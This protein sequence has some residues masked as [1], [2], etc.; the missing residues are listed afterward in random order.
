M[1]RT[2][3]SEILAAATETA[4]LAL[5]APR[6]APLMTDTAPPAVSPAPAAPSPHDAATARVI[7]EMRDTH[8]LDLQCVCLVAGRRDAC[9]AARHACSCASRGARA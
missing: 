5:L 7:G 9:A 1:V 3:P 2:N 4:P 8:Q 6:P